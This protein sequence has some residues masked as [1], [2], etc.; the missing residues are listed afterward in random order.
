[1]LVRESLCRVVKQS[2]Y[3]GLGLNRISPNASKSL[4]IYLISMV[5]NA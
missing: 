1:M 4:E 2:P 5:A 3:D